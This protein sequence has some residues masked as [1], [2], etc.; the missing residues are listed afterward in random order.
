MLTFA[1]AAGPGIPERVLAALGDPCPSDLPFRA[2]D[3][4]LWSNPA[5]TVVFAGWQ[6]DVDMGMGSRWHRRPDGLTA[7]TG[8]VWPRSGVWREGEPWSSQLASYLHRHP[9]SGGTDGLLGVFTAVALD[10][11]GRGTVAGDALGTS[12]RYKAETEGVTILSS[13]ASLA[14]RLA[15]RGTPRRDVLGV[16]WLAYAGYPIGPRTGY[17]GVAVVPLGVHADVTG[18][19][20]AFRQAPPPWRAL[21]A[22]ERHA[23]LDEVYSDIVTSIRAA[24]SYPVGRKVA[25]LTGGK[26]SR[27]ILAV[28]LAEGLADRFEYRT[29]GSPT[30]PDVVIAKRLADRFGLRHEVGLD[31]DA[32]QR[33]ASRNVRLALE[34]PDS[35]AR[36][37]VLR[38]NVGASGGMRVA[39]QAQ[40][41]APPCGDRVAL[42]G[43][44]GEALSTNYPGTTRLRNHAE[45]R[46]TLLV[47]MKLGAAGI[48]TPDALERYR[49]DL[50]AIAYERFTYDDAPQ[51]VSEGLFLRHRMP[52]WFGATQEVDEANR[53]F[54]LH[55]PVAV[56]LAFSLGVRD[57]HLQWIPRELY[58]RAFPELADQHSTSG[59]W[60]TVAAPDRVR[61]P[62]KRPKL[63]PA[64]TSS[65]SPPPPLV[66]LEA[67][68]RN[69]SADVE[70]MRR[71]LL[72]EPSN[73]VFDILDR[74]AVEGA[75][76]GFDGL[77]E[78]SKQQL[79]GA[80][81]AAIW[82]GGH[83]ITLSP[84]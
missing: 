32:Q 65:S 75:V 43:L 21:L 82:R 29:L 45:L 4:I 67:R 1:L 68:R 36:K 16:G 25:E 35:S 13:R 9:L 17:E 56:R 2:S 49:R 62:R 48:L 34:H 52:R 39:W 15:S 64:A 38:L 14:A 83:E 5:G 41:S 74:T 70:V 7:F 58:R 23:L 28:L 44:Y 24:L 31:P 19:G 26:D 46:Q 18:A 8:H 40:S 73:P 77:P 51:D 11:D 84:A 69:E 10:A 61:E 59:D 76:A 42:C 54:P 78:P 81:S 66:G 57:R 22:G 30:I 50:E 63:R 79:Y 12:V 47:N 27:L 3:H 60:P 55:S 71:Y 37:R 80:L 20:V 6:D 53:V 72:D 33:A